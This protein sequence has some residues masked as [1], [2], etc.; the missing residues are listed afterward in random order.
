MLILALQ[1]VA[2][3]NKVAISPRSIV[4]EKINALFR[5]KEKIVHLILS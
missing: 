2:F 1:R 5:L 4:T 3:Q